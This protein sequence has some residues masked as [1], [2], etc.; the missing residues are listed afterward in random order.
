MDHRS[1]LLIGVAIALSIT[2]SQQQQ[3]T[4]IANV[5]LF[6]NDLPS[7]PF[8]GLS[9]FA[10]CCLLC[11]KTPECQAWTFTNDGENACWLKSCIGSD[12]RYNQSSN[13]YFVAFI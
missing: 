9:S 4:Y 13:T 10:E 1:I 11:Q 3:C 2:C 8:C 5:D 12:V 7:S 6:G